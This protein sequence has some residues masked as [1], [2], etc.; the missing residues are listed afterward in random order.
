VRRKLKMSNNKIN[1]NVSK[2]KG[3]FKPEK[4]NTQ[5]IQELIKDK[6]IDINKTKS[7][8][9]RY[10]QEVVRTRDALI[11]KNGELSNMK[12]MLELFFKEKK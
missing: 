2:D 11:Y 7:I 5:K 1:K 4:T 8:L 6:E 3:K 9:K 12:S 10:E